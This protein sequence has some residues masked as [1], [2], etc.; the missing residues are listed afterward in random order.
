MT[1]APVPLPKHTSSSGIKEEKKSDKMDFMNI[2]K[3]CSPSGAM[4]W[5]VE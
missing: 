5:L 2:K 3:G 1:L 4:Q